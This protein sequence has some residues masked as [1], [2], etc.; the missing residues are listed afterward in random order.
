MLARA[1]ERA[2]GQKAPLGPKSSEE[3]EAVRNVV[4]VLMHE[5][6]CI[7]HEYLS[8]NWDQVEE[9]YDANKH[10]LRD[11]GLVCAW[12]SVASLAVSSWPLSRLERT[13]KVLSNYY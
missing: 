12:K 1:A 6:E 7:L 8:F 10:L 9:I 4:A 5:L 11:E 13:V 3:M 2:V